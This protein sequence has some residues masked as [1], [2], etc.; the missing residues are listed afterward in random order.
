MKNKILKKLFFKIN[1]LTEKLYLIIYQITIVFTLLFY[2]LIKGASGHQF[3]ITN[4]EITYFLL[5]FLA[6]VLTGFYKEKESFSSF[7]NKIILYLL[8]VFSVVTFGIALYFF[9]FSIT[10]DYEFWESPIMIITIFLILPIIFIWCNFYLIK[11]IIKKIRNN[12]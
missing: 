6:F 11:K 5:L 7:F 8:L 10:F 2:T 1:Y 9:Y 4:E 3:K 12:V